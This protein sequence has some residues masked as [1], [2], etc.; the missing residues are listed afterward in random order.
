ME[1]RDMT[2]SSTIGTFSQLCV[3]IASPV[4]V[5]HI[6]SST[7]MGRVGTTYDFAICQAAAAK[8]VTSGHIL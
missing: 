1:P 3:V 2:K 7:L 5:I 8:L 4:T 6:L